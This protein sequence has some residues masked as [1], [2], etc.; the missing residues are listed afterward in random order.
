MSL[1]IICS[2]HLIR[3]PVGGHSWHHLQYLIGFMRLGHEV[4]FFEDYGWPNSCYDPSTS[5]MTADPSYGV[6][7]MSRLFRSFGLEDR[8]CY[9]AED[10]TA[11]GISRAQLT[12][13]C[14]ESDVYFNLS[15]I[16]WIPE[17]ELCRRRVLVDTDPVFT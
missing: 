11:R 15:N 3:H 5:E 17:L 12:D 8:W 14:R 13:A 2:G 1:K 6:E 9:L 10:G 16:N 7:Y 4:T